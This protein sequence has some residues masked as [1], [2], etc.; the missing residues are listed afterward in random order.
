M[1]DPLVESVLRDIRQEQFALLYLQ[2]I[3]GESKARGKDGLLD[4]N[5]ATWGVFFKAA[6]NDDGAFWDSLATIA[7]VEGSASAK[8]LLE[9]TTLETDFNLTWTV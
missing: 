6:L 5:Y 1:F 2:A 4:S 7:D 3:N 9:D 8:A